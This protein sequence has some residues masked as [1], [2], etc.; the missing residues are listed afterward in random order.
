MLAQRV[1][2]LWF[3]SFVAGSILLGVP[4][5]ASAAA[6]VCPTQARLY[7]LPAGLTW[8]HPR[9]NCTDA[10]GDPIE[11][12]ITDEPEFGTF[13]PPGQIPIDQVRTYTAKA[14]AANNRDVI[15][16]VAVAGGEESNEFQVDVWILPAHSAPVCKD[17]AL[18]MQAGASV[19]IAPECVDA[20][21]D[22][23][24]GATDL[25]R[26]RTVRGQG[27]HDV[28]R[29]R[30]MEADVG[31]ADGDDLGRILARATRADERQ[32]RT[33][34]RPSRAAVTS[35]AP[36]RHPAHGDGE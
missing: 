27:H 14:D 19:A 3:V 35:R 18:N 22:D 34:A 11:I 9:P 12:R 30:R 6:P 25:H 10:D 1:S 33:D 20:D 24:T 29:R 2:R 26:R 21:G 36:A 17:L 4:A 28:R 16:F 31:A 13:D 8:T 15:K 7:Q 32:D 23:F 5:T